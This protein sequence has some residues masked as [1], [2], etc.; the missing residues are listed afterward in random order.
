MKFYVAVA[1]ACTIMACGA[2]LGLPDAKEDPTLNEGGV[3]SSSSGGAAFDAASSGGGPDGGSCTDAS[4]TNPRA[5]GRCGHDCDKGTCENGVCQAFAIATA[6]SAPSDTAVNSK[7][8]YWTARFT[9]E[10]FHIAHGT[11]ANV[12]IASGLERPGELA[13]DDDQVFIASEGP[14]D[15]ETMSGGVFTC[16]AL[17][18]TPA[19]NVTRLAEGAYTLGLTLSDDTVFFVG[20]LPFK[21]S[22]VAKAGGAVLPISDAYS[23]FDNVAVAGNALFASNGYG[24]FHFSID[25]GS[26][27]ANALEDRFGEGQFTGGVFALNGRLYWT[28][29]GGDGGTSKVSVR[30]VSGPTNVVDYATGNLPLPFEVISDDKYVYWTNFGSINDFSES[31]DGAIFACPVAGCVEPPLLLA[32]DLKSPL[33]LSV[34]DNYLYFASRG[35]GTDRDGSVMKV[36]KP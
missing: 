11:E 19:S 10:V 28:Q 32:H 14:F 8:V 5:C 12:L 34:D 4:P 9:G 23:P 33:G 21:A 15:V 2:V 18:C 35:T 6:Q 27:D 24:V 16:P 7:G 31:R 22:S 25:A 26:A 3:A 17:G 36:V 1:A 29:V 13:V 20:E 30:D